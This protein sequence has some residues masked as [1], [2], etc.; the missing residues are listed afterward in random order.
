MMNEKQSEQEGTM[1][2]EI[3]QSTFTRL[4]G[5]IGKCYRIAIFHGERWDGNL[6]R[7]YR[8]LTGARKAAQRFNPSATVIVV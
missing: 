5:E 7:F 6:R 3:R 4:N 8:T 2:L 1:K